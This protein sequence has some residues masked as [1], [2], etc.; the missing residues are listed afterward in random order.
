MDRPVPKEPA[1]D[2]NPGHVGAAHEQVFAHRG[3][4][5]CIFDAALQ[6]RSA[7]PQVAEV[8]GLPP[9]LLKTGTPLVDWLRHMA[10]TGHY[11]ARDLEAEVAWRLERFA[12]PDTQ[13]V[14]RRRPDGRMLETRRTPL[15]DGGF[16]MVCVDVTDLVASEAAQ[17]ENRRTLEVLL[18]QTE[19][20]FWFIDN[21]HRT[22]D[23]N[24]AMCR[25]LGISREDLAGRSIWEFV[26]SENEA[27]F[28]AQ[29]ARRERG[30]ANTYEITLTR[31][32]GG[33]VVCI[34]NATPIHDAQGVKIGAIGLFSDVTALRATEAQA[35]EAMALAAEKSRVLEITLD[36]LDQGVLGFDAELRVHSWNRRAIE[37]LELPPSLL[38]RRPTLVE[39]GR[40][41][42]DQGTFGPHLER[43][44]GTWTR[45]LVRRHIGDRMSAGSEP[46]RYRR[47]RADGVVIE[48]RTHLGS[49]GG[50]VRTYTDVTSEVQ[51]AEA[52]LAAKEEAERANRAKSE[53]LSRMSHEL[54]TP[55]NAILGFGQLM[56]RDKG[57]PLSTSQQARLQQILQGGEHLLT[58]INE[59]LDLARI[60]TGTLQ[61]SPQAVDADGLVDDC[62]RLV[63]PVARTQPVRLHGREGLAGPMRA[64][65]TRLRQVLL[66]LLANAI[67]FNA[68]QGDVRVRCSRQGGAG[69]IEVID[70][71]PGLDDAQQQRLFRAF[72]RLGADRQAIEGT[73][74]GLAL[75]RSLVEAMGGRIG[76][77]SAP[78]QGSCFWVELPLTTA[79]EQPEP[80]GMKRVL[81]V[82]DNAVNQLVMQGMLAH[83]PQITL[84]LADSADSGLAMASAEPPDLVLLD[85]HLPGASGYEVLKSMRADKRLRRL[86]ILAVS[87][88]ALPRDLARARES[89]FDGFLTKPLDLPDL[90][91]AVDRWLAPRA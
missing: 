87:A 27:V 36:S 30:Q 6:L 60:E 53:F 56:Q 1:A 66:N 4:G 32:D 41:Q 2:A 17:F 78:G 29:V 26:D 74:I 34:N 57:Q 82:E 54:R 28:R 3:D 90:L 22:T 20:G 80:Q 13:T 67:K 16:A 81:Y 12:E 91:A 19:E 64:D 45:E 8:L 75:S 49:D 42:Q 58:L 5:V 88:N 50:Q 69:R 84:Q 71:G 43:I 39:I 77:H 14:R 25:L 11:G 86:P 48:I 72:E 55:L 79:A 23:A 35:R 68:P 9:A 70:T 46:L 24:P 31:P 59:V 15:A 10:A 7:N 62:L 63:E 85:I 21:D 47:R 83:R 44:E 65:P 40:W 33:R 38:E 61:V 73:G 89:G 37:L 52:L 51:T 76:V 18:A